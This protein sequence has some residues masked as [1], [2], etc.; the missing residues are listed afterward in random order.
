M[1]YKKPTLNQIYHAY[2]DTMHDGKGH[3]EVLVN[4]T[5]VDVDWI[6]CDLI[7]TIME[8]PGVTEAVIV[9][10]LKQDVEGYVSIKNDG[11]ERV[12]DIPFQYIWT[13]IMDPVE[14]G[15]E[16]EQS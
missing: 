4:G 11:L 16:E 7:T 15:L 10:A 14:L 5:H 12:G 1:S 6:Y 2:M 9:A 3:I 8:I 13:S